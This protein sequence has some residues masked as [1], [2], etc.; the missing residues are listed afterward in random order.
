MPFYVG[1]WNHLVKLNI[2]TYRALVT[3]FDPGSS[4][5]A[6]RLLSQFKICQKAQKLLKVELKMNSTVTM[7]CC[8]FIE[9]VIE[10]V[11]DFSGSEISGSHNIY[12]SHR[13]KVITRTERQIIIYLLILLT[14]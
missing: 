5:F 8:C 4:L 10:A 13:R 1:S 7:L 11:D 6:G 2:K 12:F 9:F 14:L 3:V